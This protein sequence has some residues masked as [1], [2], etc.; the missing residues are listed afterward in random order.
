ML[1]LIDILPPDGSD[2]VS[3]VQTI[4][5][6]LAQF[7]EELA[8]RPQWLVFNKIDQLPPEEADALI[9][10]FREA[11]G[12][13]LPWFAISAVTGAGCEALCAAAQR[14]VDERAAQ[15]ARNPQQEAQ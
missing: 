5:Q 1:H 7:S 13:A 15:A 14:W 2:V 10:G 9:A 4:N 3:N 8:A 12:N 11:L 6:E